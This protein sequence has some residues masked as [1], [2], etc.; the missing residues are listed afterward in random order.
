M[1]DSSDSL[2]SILAEG[3]GAGATKVSGIAKEALILSAKGEVCS[4]ARHGGKSQL[5]SLQIT[6]GARTVSPG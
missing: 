6:P 3:E 2:A 5:R 4:V 1:S